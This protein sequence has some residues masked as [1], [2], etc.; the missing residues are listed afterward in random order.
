MIKK[1]FN[2]KSFQM[3]FFIC[4][5]AIEFLA[6]TTTIHIEIVESMWDKLNHFVAF[7]VLYVLLSLAYKNLSTVFRV[8]LLLIFGI[9]IE[10]VQELIERSHFSTLDI[11]ADSIGI[12]I[13]FFVSYF[14]G[15]F[16]NRV[17]SSI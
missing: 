14:F 7:F 17:D 2:Q 1:L 8:V 11:V 15:L 3:Y 4:L 10:L 5:G 9:Q 16:K 12:M 6:T 13:G